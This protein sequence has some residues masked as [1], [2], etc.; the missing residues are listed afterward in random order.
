MSAFLPCGGLDIV[1]PHHEVKAPTNQARKGK[2]LPSM[3]DFK[4]SNR[5]SKQIIHKN[6]KTIN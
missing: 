6:K 4:N 2:R 3:I 5:I 1:G